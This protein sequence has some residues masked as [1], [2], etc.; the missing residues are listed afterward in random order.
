MGLDMYLTAKKFHT[1]HEKVDGKLQHRPRKLVD[2]FPLEGENLEI[3]Y[4]RKN[5]WLHGFI[6]ENF[7]NGVDECQPI[8][9][10]AADLTMVAR[11]LEKWADDPS[12]FA[13]TDGFFFGVRPEDE[14]YEE[15]RDEYRKDAVAEA[16][17]LYRAVDWLK[18]DTEGREY[19]SVTYQASW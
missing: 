9:L 19:R 11:K 14:H 8:E 3:M 10:D 7:A 18:A 12:E 5:H 13:P 4:W 2:G 17:T 6:V 1:V 16:Q 15:V